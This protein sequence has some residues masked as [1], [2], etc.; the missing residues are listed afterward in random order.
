VTTRLDW[1]GCGNVRDVGGLPAGDGYRIRTGALVRADDLCQLTPQS[2]AALRAYGVVRVLDLRGS[3]E[4]ERWPSPLADDPVYRWTPFVDERADLDRNPD[5]EVTVLDLYLGSVRR[6]AG[7]IAVALAAFA[8]A[9][10]GGVLVHCLEGK[11]RTGVLVALALRLAGVPDADIAADYAASN[12]QTCRPETIT[13][14]LDHLDRRYGGV[15]P[16]LTAHG[17]TAGQVDALRSRLLERAP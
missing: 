6:N 8:D 2:L 3:W 9:P 10:P 13:G 14:V 4:T 16:Y 5:E 1:P 7:H 11:D 15:A 12:E 17:L